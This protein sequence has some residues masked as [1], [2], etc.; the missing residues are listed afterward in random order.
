MK[1]K[2]NFC[3]GKGYDVVSGHGCDGDA[4]KCEK[5][6]PVPV[7]EVCEACGGV[8]YYEVKEENNE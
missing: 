1:K 4:K 5:E 6:C 8:G 3:D 7:Q 2:C